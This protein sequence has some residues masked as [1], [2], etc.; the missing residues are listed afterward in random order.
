MRRIDPCGLLDQAAVTAAVGA[1]RFIGPGLDADECEMRFDPATQINSVSVSMSVS[2]VGDGGTKFQVGDRDAY[3]LDGGDLCHISLFFDEDRAFFYS[4]SGP[5]EQL[6]QKLRQIVIGSAPQ[7][8][9]P[10]QRA[11]STTMPDTKGWK[12]DPCTG[13]TAAFAPG[14][15]FDFLG[16]NPFECD[17]YAGEP[18][19]SETAR[20]RYTVRYINVSTEHARYVPDEDRRLRIVGVDATETSGD[21]EFCQIKV[22]VGADHTFPIMTY[23][24]KTEKWLEAIHVTGYGCAETRQVAV[25][26]VKAHRNG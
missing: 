15:T 25:A 21:N 23:D 5:P 24:G 2:A 18:D 14:Q 7:L 9:N 1:P 17:V 10:P 6:C 20:N 11:D 19:S 12:I 3:T 4:I 13:L 16:L 26:A 8:D 22:F